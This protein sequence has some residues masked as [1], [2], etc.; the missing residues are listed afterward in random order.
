[1][2]KDYELPGTEH[3]YYQKEEKPKRAEGPDMERFSQKRTGER[4][5]RSVP[6]QGMVFST[7]SDGGI[8]GEGTKGGEELESHHSN[9]RGSVSAKQGSI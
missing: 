9:Q 2:Q 7:I 6:R 8:E 4:K 5:G 3:I 1:L